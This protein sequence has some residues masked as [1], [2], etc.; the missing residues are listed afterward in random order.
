MRNADMQGQPTRLRGAL[1]SVANNLISEP[2]VNSQSSYK[3]Q[4]TMIE[5]KQKARI[6]KGFDKEPITWELYN[7]VV[8]MASKGYCDSHVQ[9]KGHSC[10]IPAL[11]L[12]LE[13]L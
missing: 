12:A 4:V 5:M 6:V 11:E 8:G 1:Y 13:I 3:D 2:L 9:K 7:K 10:Y